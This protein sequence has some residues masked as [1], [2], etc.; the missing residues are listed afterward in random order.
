MANKKDPPNWLRRLLGGI[1]K[2]Y[3]GDVG[4]QGYKGAIIGTAGGAAV[5]TGM[6]LQSRG[7][8]KEAFMKKYYPDKAYNKETMKDEFKRFRKGIDEMKTGGAWTRN[9]RKHG[10]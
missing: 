10:S 5:G 9:S 1:G 4:K 2:D 6:G 3:K 7:K 8:K